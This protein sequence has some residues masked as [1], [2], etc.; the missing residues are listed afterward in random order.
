MYTVSPLY[1]PSRVYVRVPG[2]STLSSWYPRRTA[3]RYPGCTCPCRSARALATSRISLGN[4]IP[5]RIAPSPLPRTQDA[6]V[7]GRTLIRPT[8]DVLT[9]QTPSAEPYPRM[10][11]ERPADSLRISL[12]EL[13]VPRPRRPAHTAPNDYSGAR[14]H[15]RTAPCRPGAPSA[16]SHAPPWP[17]RGRQAG[18][19]PPP[20]RARPLRRCDRPA[21][22]LC[23]YRLPNELRTRLFSN[24]N[25]FYNAGSRPCTL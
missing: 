21:P 16:F 5:L 15:P 8:A 20:S 18:T 6:Q 10:R 11:A 14:R 4:R 23:L 25:S 24:H 19:H 3:P 17:S 7:P 9:S 12:G 22:P 13:Q 1:P 2:S